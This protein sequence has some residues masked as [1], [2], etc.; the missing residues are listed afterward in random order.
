MGGNGELFNHLNIGPDDSFSPIV[1]KSI[2]STNMFFNH[3]NPNHSF[4]IDK[5]SP[6]PIDFFE[7]YQTP[8]IY[9]IKDVIAN[10]RKTL[11]DFFHYLLSC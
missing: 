5:A 4:L 1:L 3:P 2:C 7:G 10:F 6:C 8:I 9:M 11:K